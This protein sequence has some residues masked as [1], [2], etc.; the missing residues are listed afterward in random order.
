MVRGWK[1]GVLLVGVVVAGSCT[2]ERSRAVL[3]QAEPESGA[4]LSSAGA[5]EATQGVTEAPGLHNI[6]RV[7]DKVISGSLPEGVEGFESL[8]KM[9]VK[10]VISVDGAPPDV[11]GAK[12]EGMRY[13]HLPIGYNGI[14]KAR[15]LE[16]ARALR[17]LPGPI[18]VHC[19]H[20]RHRSPAAA[21]A[22]TV[23]LGE[24]TPQEGERILKT[25]GTS[26]DY[27]GLYACVREARPASA[28][29]LAAASGEFPEIAKTPSFVQAMVETQ[30]AYDH[31]VEVRDA[32]WSVPPEHP[33]LV[34]LA[35]AGRLEN[36]LR[37]MIDDP[38]SK[39]YPAEFENL[40]RRSQLAAQELEDA[41]AS[42]APAADLSAKLKQVNTSC[43][44]C[45]VAYRDTKNPS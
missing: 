43:K 24:I 1:A 6:V 13:V 8:R 42:S 18:Y 5:A 26:P 34:P 45:H 41:L 36:L 22:A 10:T 17:D 31:L 39:K 4:T 23:A 29:E 35:E 21:A 15:K 3:T 30:H 16:L 44:E 27:R 40:M 25:A 33:D 14:S 19:H 32:G 37:A 2:H 9:G 12:R 20:G 11:E 38:E 7:T 28:Q